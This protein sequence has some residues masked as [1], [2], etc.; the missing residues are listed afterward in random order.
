M[1]LTTVIV[2]AVC[3]ALGFLIRAMMGVGKPLDVSAFDQRLGGIE[4][5]LREE[6]TQARREQADAARAARE[7]LQ[8][9]ISTLGAAVGDKVKESAQMQTEVNQTL[10]ETLR[11]SLN[12]NVQRI[13]LLRTAVGDGLQKIQ[14]DNAEKL[15]KMRETVDEKLH[16][17]LEKR[18]G[19]SFKIVSERLENVQ[20]GLGEMQTLASGVGDLKKVLTNV[21]TRGTWGEVLLG[22]LLEQ[23]LTPEQ[24]SANVATKKTNERVEFAIRMPGQGQD[25][26]W[27]PIDSKFPK[28]DY[29]RLL[30]AQEAGNADEAHAAGKSLEERIKRFAQDVCEKYVS[31]PQTTDFCIIFL[32][33]EGLYAEVIRRTALVELLQRQHRVMVAGP[34]VLGALLNSLQMGFRT[35]AIQKRSSEVWETLGAVKTE[36]GRY[37]ELMNKVKLKLEQAGKT[38]E[39]TQVRSRAIYRQLQNVERLSDEKTATI[40]SVETSAEKFLEAVIEENEAEAGR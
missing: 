19:E 22:N 33:S 6:A 20:K 13:D 3:A 7:E 11:H 38:I 12:E 10:A 35:L 2:G 1:I 5:A 34:T 26:V 14:K 9:S 4:K 29:E 36:F 17:T 16:A 15:E 31:P 28:E 37:G 23:V 30:T 32:P 8:K 39:E 18:L 40:F 25:P 27:L 24:Y 21:K